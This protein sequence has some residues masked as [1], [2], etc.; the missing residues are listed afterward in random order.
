MLKLK[1]PDPLTRAV[2]GGKYINKKVKMCVECGIGQRK[3]IKCYITTPI[4]YN[5]IIPYII[6]CVG[7]KHGRI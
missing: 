3:L 7:C 1:F 6:A 2:H 5:A 4:S